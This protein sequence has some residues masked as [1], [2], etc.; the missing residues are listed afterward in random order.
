MK[1]IN[2]KPFKY[3]KG[4]KFWDKQTEECETEIL[5]VIANVTSDSKTEHNIESA[6]CVASLLLM[7]KMEHNMPSASLVID[8]KST[9]I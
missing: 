5:S 1:T 6:A 3:N 7:Y 9:V 2:G 4:T 8:H